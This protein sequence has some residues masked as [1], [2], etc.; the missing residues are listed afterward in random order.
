M[1]AVIGTSK[2]F[3][4]VLMGL[5]FGMNSTPGQVDLATSSLDYASNP[6]TAGKLGPV[7]VGIEGESLDSVAYEDKGLNFTFE[8][9]AS[10][11]VIT[12]L[13]P[14]SVHAVATFYD[15]GWGQH[16]G[17]HPSY[18]V[19]RAN[20]QVNFFFALERVG[21]TPPWEPPSL[22]VTFHAFGEGNASSG[23]AP[24]DPATSVHVQAM[25][26]VNGFPTED[27]AAAGIRSASFDSTILLWLAESTGYN[28]QYSGYV[29]AACG[30]Q[31]RATYSVSWLDPN[32][33]V[34][35]S[36]PD[37]GSADATVDPELYLDQEAFDAMYGPESFPLEQYYT[38]E[39]SE[40]LSRSGTASIRFT[41]VR[42]N[43]QG[44]IQL[45][46]SGSPGDVC[47]ILA[48]TNLIDW[49]VIAA[50]LNS[51]GTAQF[52]DTNSTNYNQR[53]YRVSK[54]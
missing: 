44:Q 6:G 32:N 37:A 49:Q 51:K 14:P 38:I 43:A 15:N 31:S 2:I 54:P 10:A 26:N 52:T 5:T 29:Y 35:I 16:Y 45:T 39:F 17:G 25:L 21:P 18:V 8:A 24:G 30:A 4:G 12:G 53:F 20:G 22:P 19:G 27:F 9:Q 11:H 3:A 23:P 28:P 46:F 36:N 7:N 13:N 50:V 40:N 48:S 41:D 47:R 34:V 42:H 1:R 33:P